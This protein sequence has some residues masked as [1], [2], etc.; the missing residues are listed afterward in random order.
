MLIIIILLKKYSFLRSLISLHWV[1]HFAIECCGNLPFSLLCLEIP[2]YL[3]TMPPCIARQ[4]LSLYHVLRLSQALVA[5][6]FIHTS[7]YFWGCF[8]TKYLKCT[9]IGKKNIF[10]KRYISAHFYIFFA[11]FMH[12]I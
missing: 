3:P 4:L 2:N 1:K 8:Y 5:K 9:L 7:P 11:K 6:L 10:L 12:L